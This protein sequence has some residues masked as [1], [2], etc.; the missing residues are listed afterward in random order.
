MGSAN[1]RVM[2]DWSATHARFTAD[3]LDDC[4]TELLSLTRTL[5][6]Y[7]GWRTADAAVLAVAAS[8]PGNKKQILAAA[9]YLLWV[10]DHIR[11]QSARWASAITSSCI[12]YAKH[13]DQV[14]LLERQM[15]S[16]DI[17]QPPKDPPARPGDLD[18]IAML[19]AP[20]LAGLD[21]AREW[22]GQALWAARQNNT[23][24]MATV[25]QHIEMLGHWLERQK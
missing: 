19:P 6:S 23:E 25:C 16:P 11:L 3:L 5:D 1:E 22:C 13:A 9:A 24:G 18:N 14:A 8:A 7:I 10:G 17:I 4:Q 21:R 20:Y 15:V 2:V 12:G